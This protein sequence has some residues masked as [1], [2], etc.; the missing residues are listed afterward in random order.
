MPG[1]GPTNI[2]TS[3]RV[4][5]SAEDKLAQWKR[6][7]ERQGVNWG[8]VSACTLRSAI[9]VAVNEGYHLTFAPA[10][11]GL[12]CCLKLWNGGK[13]V[14]EYAI[15]AAEVQELLDTLIDALGSGAEDVRQIYAT[16]AD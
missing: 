12:G 8:E 16:G 11:G 3:K 10:A 7:K 9:S 13:D 1:K 4:A 6:N 5:G 15:D 14:K 2:F